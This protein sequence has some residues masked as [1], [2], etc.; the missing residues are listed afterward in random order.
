MSTALV[1]FESHHGQTAKIAARVAAALGA[2]GVEARALPLRELGDAPIAADLVVLGSP[3]RA[4]RHLPRVVRFARAHRAELERRPAAFFSVSLAR[5]RGTAEADGYVAD[6]LRDTGWS[7]LRTATFAGGLPYRRFNFL[8]RWIM[9][10]IS[11]SQGGDTDT[12]RDHEY[13]DWADV[14]RFA[15]GLAAALPARRMLS[16]SRSGGAA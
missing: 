16:R 2:A 7:P 14:D 11:K 9:K 13:T 12:S 8:L 5:S 4:G 15:R 10:A 1:L 6:F 3:V